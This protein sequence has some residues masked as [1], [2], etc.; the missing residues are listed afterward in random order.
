[1]TRGGPG[2]STQLIS[3]Y[4]YQETFQS[5]AAGY[6]SSIAL[7]MLLFAGIVIAGFAILRKRGWQV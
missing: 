7:A 4:M 2:Y 1:M 3:T 6:A 5:D